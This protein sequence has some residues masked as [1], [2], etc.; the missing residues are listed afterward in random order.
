MSR[1]GQRGFSL[2]EALAVLAIVGLVLMTVGPLMDE[3]MALIAS[4]DAASAAVSPER[5]GALLR[6]DLEAGRVAGVP[7]RRGALEVSL[8]GGGSVR[9]ALAGATL[10]REARDESGALVGRRFELAGVKAFTWQSLNDDVLEVR[11]SWRTVSVASPPTGQAASRYR[12]A[13]S[14]AVWRVARRGGGEGR[15]W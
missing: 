14:T 6:G 1:Q 3:S 12:T 7:T 5:L 4:S 8:P 2:V 9:W 10:H 15:S 13:T 11:L